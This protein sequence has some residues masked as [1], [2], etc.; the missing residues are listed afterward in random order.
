MY[1]LILT[2]LIAA[3]GVVIFLYFR[4]RHRQIVIASGIGAAAKPQVSKCHVKKFKYA[5]GFSTSKHSFCSGLG[6]ENLT[7]AA[8]AAFHSGSPLVAVSNAVHF[9]KL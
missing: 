5:D 9:V 3:L 4:L 7:D 2:C 8:A 1:T 6:L